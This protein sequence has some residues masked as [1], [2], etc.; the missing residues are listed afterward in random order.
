MEFIARLRGKVGSILRWFWHLSLFKKLAIISV[1]LIIGWFGYPRVFGQKNNQ[2]QYQTAQ[3]ERGTFILSVT[4]SGTISSSNTVSI[5]TSATGI[6]ST[7]YVQNGDTVA[8]GQKIADI[9]LDQDSQQRQ[10]AAWASYLASQN[11]LNSAKAK[12]NSLQSALF[13]ANQ[14]FVTDRGISNPSDAQKADPKYIEENAEWLQAEADYNNQAGVISQAEAALSSAWLSYQ[15]TSASIKAPTAGTITN[16]TLSPGVSITDSNDQ[17]SSTTSNTTTASS[18]TVGAITIPGGRIQ[19]S[20]NLSEIDVVTVK[21][22]QKVTLTLDA[23]PDKT[24]TGKVASIDTNGSV[25]SG[26]TTYPATITLD[27][28]LP[29]IYPNMAVS[30]KII[31]SIKNDVLLVPSGA[32][33]TQNGQSSVRVMKNGAV[34]DVIVETGEAN[35]TQVEIVSGLS[36]GDTVIAGQ[37]GGGTNQQGSGSPF[38]GFGGRGGGGQRIFIQGGGGGRR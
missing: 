11:T 30:V 35:D 29:N 36:E 25:S 7:V 5:T 28:G 37:T 13:K 14:A 12:M 8:E 32:V 31:T 3:A 2:P 19:A 33:Q 21:S 1:L 38:S 18:Q 26:V 20:V 10:T 24:F 15:Q 4:A 16:F 9:T 6:V 22:G 23:F 27:S 34:Q 17:G